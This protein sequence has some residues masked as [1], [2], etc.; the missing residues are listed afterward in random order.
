MSDDAVDILVLHGAEHRVGV[1]MKPHV[2][3]VLRKRRR[4]MRIVGHIEN[5]GWASGQHLKTARPIHQ[6]EPISNFL[7]ADRQA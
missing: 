3:Q 4:G 7:R 6:Y 5:D 1:G 2:I